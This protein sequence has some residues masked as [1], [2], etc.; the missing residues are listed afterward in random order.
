MCS[1]DFFLACLAILF[2]PVSVWIKRGICSADSFINLALCM[3]GFIPGLLHAWYII[4]KYP[5]NHGGYAALEVE[6]GA[7]YPNFYYYAPGAPGAPGQQQ[8]YPQQFPG[9]PGAP[10]YAT[11]QAPYQSHPGTPAPP[12]QQQHHQ[13]QGQQYPHG[14]G[15]GSAA[16]GPSSGAGEQQGL[17]SYAEVVKGDFKVQT[18]D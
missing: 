7:R 1:V 8:Q 10:S 18:Q 14:Q 13:Q 2:P 11:F 16:A 17:P 6:N 15:Q 9:A 3:L 5:D 12:Q 4:A